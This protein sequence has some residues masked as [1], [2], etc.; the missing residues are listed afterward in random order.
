MAAE[1]GGEARGA[2][3]PRGGRAVHGARGRAGGR[4]PRAVGG[5]PPP[6]CGLRFLPGEWK[7]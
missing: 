5:Q 7:G 2:G 3:Q 4:V 1:H 6:A